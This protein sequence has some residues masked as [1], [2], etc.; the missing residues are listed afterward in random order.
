MESM[1]E[2]PIKS[3]NQLNSTRCDAM[4][5]ESQLVR[6][7]EL[8]V[9][10]SAC[11]KVAV[12]SRR[13]VANCCMVDWMSR[14][15]GWGWWSMVGSCFFGSL[16]MVGN[17]HHRQAPTNHTHQWIEYLERNVVV[18][19]AGGFDALFRLFGVRIQ[20]GPNRV[21]LSAQPTLST[22]YANTHTRT[23]DLYSGRRVHIYW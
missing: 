9:D 18:G 17:R 14:G 10:G 4:R 6:L 15:W 8:E 19:V 1:V 23:H 20:F 7:G 22:Q 5:I 3:R 2:V 13:T 21:E 11:W 12:L 16:P